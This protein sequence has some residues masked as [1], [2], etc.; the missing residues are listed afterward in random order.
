M[1]IRLTG[2]RE[3]GQRFIGVNLGARVVVAVVVGLRG[4]RLERLKS[5]FNGMPG[6]DHSQTPLSAT[7]KL[8]NERSAQVDAN[9]QW[10]GRW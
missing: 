1:V 2:Q 8:T 9:D 6:N 7:K 10:M 3:H 5:L 4:C